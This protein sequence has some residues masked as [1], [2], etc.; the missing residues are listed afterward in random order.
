VMPQHWLSFAFSWLSLIE[1]GKGL[2]L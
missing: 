1:L 2:K